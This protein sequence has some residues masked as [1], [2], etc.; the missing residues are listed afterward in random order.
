MSREAWGNDIDVIIGGCSNEG[1]LFELFLTQKPK[2]LTVLE[3]FNFAVPAEF[4]L[5]AASAKC[6]EHG[7]M[8]KKMYYGC[9]EPSFNNKE[10]FFCVR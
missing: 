6:S 9:T 1:L 5:D 3:N 4:G 8:M 7:K 10:G 2:I